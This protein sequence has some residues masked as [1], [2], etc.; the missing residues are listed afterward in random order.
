ME[1][2]KTKGNSEQ[3]KLSRQDPLDE[4]MPGLKLM[5][6]LDRAA[7]E[8]GIHSNELSEMLGMR[9][10]D[11][12]RLRHGRIDVVKLPRERL[13][14][15]AD[16]LG[17]PMLAAML[18][19]EQVKPEDFYPTK[20][21]EKDSLDLKIARARNY[22]LADPEWS[23]MIP[24]GM[25]ESETP[26]DWQLYTIWCYEQATGLVLIKGTADYM[27]LLDDLENEG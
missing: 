12:S 24:R 11:L 1:N 22:I 26:L 5:A 7:L 10:A 8:R 14:A 3:T 16:W 25:L 27:K 6:A 21:G 9:S 13:Q 2:K 4:S 17:I 23:G 15:I 20:F 18:L 19:A